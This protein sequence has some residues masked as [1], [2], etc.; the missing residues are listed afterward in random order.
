MPSSR[1]SSGPGDWTW[2]SC[3]AGRLFTIWT[4]GKSPLE[5][6][7]W[8]GMAKTYA[9]NRKHTLSV[10]FNSV[11]PSCL[12]LQ[13]HGLPHIRLPCPSPTLKACSNSGPW[14]WWGHSTISSSVICFSSCL[15]YFPASGLFPDEFF[16]SGG[17]ST[18]ASASP[19]VLPMNI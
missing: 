9:K 16:I 6:K 12:T 15:Q 13:L 2:V 3:I 8:R 1:R 17:Q 4:T 11:A 10:Q 18:G 7:G 14:S 5:A 19:S